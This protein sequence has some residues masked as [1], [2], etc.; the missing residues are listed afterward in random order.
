MFSK[1]NNLNKTKAVADS[2]LIAKITLKQSLFIWDLPN[3]KVIQSIERLLLKDYFNI[4]TEQKIIHQF[5][6]ALATEH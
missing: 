4:D 5:E 2:H 3:F 1:W 6:E